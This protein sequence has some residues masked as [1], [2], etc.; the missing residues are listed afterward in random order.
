MSAAIN[1]SS[2]ELVYIG[3]AARRIIRLR[4]AATRLLVEL[5][6]SCLEVVLIPSKDHDCAIRGGMIRVAHMK[7]ARWYSEFCKHYTARR[8]R[9]C[10]Y[11]RRRCDC[12]K[13]EKEKRRWYFRDRRKSKLHD[14]SIKRQHT[15]RGLEE[16]IRGSCASIYAQRLADFIDRDYQQRAAR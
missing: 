14:T 3:E 13:E 8:R 12:P 5:E 10:K 2:K 7:N 16:L 4:K 9:P 15:I 6:S 11:H 1:R